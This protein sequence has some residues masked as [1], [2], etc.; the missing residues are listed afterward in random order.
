MPPPLRY[1]AIGLPQHVI[2]RGNNRQATFFAEEDTRSTGN[3]SRTQQTR[4]N[5]M[6]MPMC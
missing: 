2:Q 1:E 6:F 5:A 3:A 4:T